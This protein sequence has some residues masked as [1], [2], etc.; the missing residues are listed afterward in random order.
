LT[1]VVTLFSI[2]LEFPR[3]GS[4]DEKNPRVDCFGLY[5]RMFQVA[6][7]P[8]RSAGAAGNA[9]AQCNSDDSHAAT[10]TN[11]RANH[12]SDEGYSNTNSDTN[13]DNHSFDDGFRAA[14]AGC[15]AHSGY[16][17]RANS[18]RHD[19]AGIHGIVKSGFEFIEG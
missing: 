5:F 17:W 13:S 8:G 4:H 11:F 6:G 2:K 14:A 7:V 18:R 19:A 15:G 16:G 10:D 9:G 1:K 3:E 12:A